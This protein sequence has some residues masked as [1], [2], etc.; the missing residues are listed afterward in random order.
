MTN[1]FNS[2]LRIKDMIIRPIDLR[3]F[4]PTVRDNGP[5][6]EVDHLFVY[7]YEGMYIY[8][9]D[10][11]THLVMP[12][13]MAL[14]PQNTPFFTYC[15][16]SENLKA[17]QCY[18]SS[19]FNGDVDVF[20]TF[21]LD[22]AVYVADIKNYKRME[23]CIESFL[24]DPDFATNLGYQLNRLS[25]FP[26]ILALYLESIQSYSQNNRDWEPLLQ[27][28]KENLHKEISIGDFANTVCLQEN[29][30]IKVFRNDFGTTPMKYFHQMK[31]KKAVELLADTDIPFH[32]VA[33]RLGF[34]DPNYFSTFF[35]KNC[36]V[37]PREFQK[38]VHKMLDK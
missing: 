12:H 35:K 15:G 18:I 16:I 32:D 20:K 31:F 7:V 29:Y 13:H 21:G 19:T 14:I 36:G 37:S 2:N 34:A 24:H 6:Y 8:R 30:F 23:A 33:S 28:M 3:P 26:E 11:V 5:Q 25:K 1:D 10:G 4:I 9:I 38:C 22:P 17:V 27:F